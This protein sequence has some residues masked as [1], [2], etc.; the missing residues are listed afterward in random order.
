VN[1]RGLGGKT[2]GGGIQILGG[3]GGVVL[4][5]KKLGSKEGFGSL[6]GGRNPI[7]FLGGDSGEGRG[8]K[9]IVYVGLV[10][11]AESGAESSL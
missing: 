4:Y 9:T 8:K 11:W 7:F 10:R 2:A 5:G 3:G 1:T 6:W